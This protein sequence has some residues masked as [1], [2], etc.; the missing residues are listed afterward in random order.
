M[1]LGYMMILANHHDEFPH[2]QMIR[3][4]MP[5]VFSRRL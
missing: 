4:E 3:E 1:K 2:A 5:V